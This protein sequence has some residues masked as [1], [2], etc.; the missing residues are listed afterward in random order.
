MKIV[1]ANE[2]NALVAEFDNQEDADSYLAKNPQYK[3][4][5]HAA[6]GLA[7]GGTL[8]LFLLFLVALGLLGFC[9]MMPS[10]ETPLQKALRERD[11]KCLVAMK[12]GN[13]RGISD[14]CP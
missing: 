5:D 7:W 2:K 12:T 14:Y 9:M 4:Q 6:K 1:I 10:T 8:K 11:N 3:I 13:L